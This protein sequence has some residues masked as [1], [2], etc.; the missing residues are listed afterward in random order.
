LAHTC[1]EKIYRHAN[2]RVLVLDAGGLL[3]T[4][5]V[6]NLSRI[7][8]N[9]GAAVKVEFSSQDPGPRERV[10]GS[11]WRS[12]TPFPGLAY[13]LGGRSLYWGGWSPRLTKA[14]LTQWP[15][16]IRAFCRILPATSA[17]PIHS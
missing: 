11:P 16:E 6:Q 10:W 8:L 7:G 1:A 2:L 3:V 9:A 4:E 14:D 15:P 17:I 5:H 13:C 12:Q